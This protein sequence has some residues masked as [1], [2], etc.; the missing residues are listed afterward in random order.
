MTEKEA[1]IVLNMLPGIGPLKVRDL[2]SFVGGATK[3]LQSDRETLLAVSGIGNK[4]VDDL[5]N[6][7]NIVNLENE[8]ELIEKAG[9]SI[10][11]FNDSQYPEL[12]KEIYDP[13]LLLYVR[14]T[15]PTN[16]DRL[17]SIVGSRR[18]TRYGRKICENISAS[19]AYNGWSIISGL[20]YGIDAVAHR[21]T[22]DAGGKTIG[23]L[24]GG[25]LRFHP[26]D[27][28][29]MAR[30]MIDNGGAVISE[31]PMEYSPNKRSF[32][33]RNRIISGLSMGTI[34]VEAG[35]KSGSLITAKFALDQGRTVFAVP[36]QV[37]NPQA[38]GTNALIKDGAV[39]TESF[40]DVL[41]EFEFSTFENIP[42]NGN[43]VTS[44]ASLE[45]SDD[46]KMIL[47]IIQEERDISADI[48]AS[49]SGLQVGSLLSVLMQL[50]MKKIIVQLPGKRY[51]PK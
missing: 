15:L 27:H 40:D 46:E 38:R 24:G 48:L 49:K 6:W 31:F 32:P 20:A 4:L 3:V 26:Q 21:A 36:G 12:L 45:L 47:D 25:L 28:L 18:V 44:V 9:V 30:E 22:L 29:N 14:G 41:E 51:A 1:L 10:V 37:D 8:L 23:V 19:A 34:V 33:M 39:L 43:V 17:I 35:F 42:E 11:T 16:N 2:I 5:L 50:E 13:P 7:N